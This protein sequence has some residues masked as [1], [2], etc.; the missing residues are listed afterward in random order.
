L[1]KSALWSVT[2]FFIAFAHFLGQYLFVNMIWK[3]SVSL[4]TILQF[5]G[6]ILLVEIIDRHKFAIQ[7]QICTFAACSYIGKS[8]PVFWRKWNGIPSCI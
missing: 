2:S 7:L 8:N 1:L 5:D 6:L 3:T 4:R